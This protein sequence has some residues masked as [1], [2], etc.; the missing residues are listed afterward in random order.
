VNAA[1]A[2]SQRCQWASMQ[3][4]V[5]FEPLRQQSD[6]HG[7]HPNDPLALFQPAGQL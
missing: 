1:T 5:L 2:C 3:A 6:P 4:G 7:C